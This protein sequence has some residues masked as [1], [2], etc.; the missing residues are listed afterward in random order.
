MTPSD[1]AN[2][3]HRRALSRFVVGYVSE[4]DLNTPAQDVE[5]AVNRC[6]RDLRF[7]TK[8]APKP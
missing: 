6:V 5:A 2:E 3:L 7:E 1:A 8:K 4:R